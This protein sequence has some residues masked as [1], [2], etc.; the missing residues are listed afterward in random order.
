MRLSNWYEM[1]EDGFGAHYKMTGPARLAGFTVFSPGNQTTY[2]IH[3]KRVSEFH[4]PCV[5]FHG[6]RENCQQY[7]EWQYSRRRSDILAKLARVKIQARRPQP[8]RFPVC[9]REK[10][11]SFCGWHLRV[12]VVI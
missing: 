4:S 10:E 5:E 7:I 6:S 12:I 3:Q 8:I 1:I 11:F 2:E 9:M